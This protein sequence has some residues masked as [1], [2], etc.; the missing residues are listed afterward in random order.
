M[1]DEE[2]KDV[3]EETPKD[4]AQSSAGPVADE[5]SKS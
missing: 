4:E 1:T 5:G 2:K 3:N